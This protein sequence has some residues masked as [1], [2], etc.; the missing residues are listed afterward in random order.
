MITKQ[1]ELIGIKEFTAIAFDPKN[2]V[3]IIYVTFISRNSDIYLS[4]KL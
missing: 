1:I 2:E 3:F 4:H